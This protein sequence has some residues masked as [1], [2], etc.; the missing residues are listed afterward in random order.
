M[1][2]ISKVVF[3]GL[4]VILVLICGSVFSRTLYD[5]DSQRIPCKIKSDPPYIECRLH[6]IGKIG[7]C[8]TNTGQLGSKFTSDCKSL[9]SCEYP[10][11][12]M[13][14]YLFA[15]AYWVGAV[16]GRDTLVSVGADGWQATREFWPDTYPR[17]E[18]IDRSGIDPRAVSE[19]DFI[20]LFTDTLT[21]P[22]YV[23]ND[24][25]DG[26]PHIPL[27]L[28]ITQR[29][30]AWSYAFAEDF[31][32]FDC[33]F[34]NIGQ[35]ALNNAYIGLYVDGDVK[36]S[37]SFEGFTDDVTGFLTSEEFPFGCGFDNDVNIAWIADNDGKQSSYDPCPYTSNS[38]VAVT[39]VRILRAP[40]D[41][42]NFSFNWWV[43]NAN[44]DYDWGPRLA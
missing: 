33:S 15:G 3:W 6:D 40:S 36:T 23:A 35:N 1:K 44:A 24:A 39:G 5:S 7:L 10:Y 16:V 19:Q 25:F 22:M 41:S 21:D 28:E 27:N 30:Y 43:S 31:V 26:R 20:A 42:A 11:P 37:G 17:G 18:I 14:S 4:A 34:K 32:L 38:L 29:S 9:P 13:Q 12:S 2:H 8:I